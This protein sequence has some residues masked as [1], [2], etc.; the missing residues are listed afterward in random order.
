MKCEMASIA[1]VLHGHLPFV[2]HPEQ[3]FYWEEHWLFE[4]IA[5]CYLPLLDALK[6]LAEQPKQKFEET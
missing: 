6:T 2:R 4:A 5:G 3:P 1:I